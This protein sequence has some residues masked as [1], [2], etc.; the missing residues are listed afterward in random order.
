[1]ANLNQDTSNT[2]GIQEYLKQQDDPWP[3]SSYHHTLY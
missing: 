3:S 2:L 1:M